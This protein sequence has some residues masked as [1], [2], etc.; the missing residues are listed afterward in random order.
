[1]WNQLGSINWT[2]NIWNTFNE[3]NKMNKENVRRSE[4]NIGFIQLYKW[5]WF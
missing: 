2:V 5:I 1:M 4:T 3:I